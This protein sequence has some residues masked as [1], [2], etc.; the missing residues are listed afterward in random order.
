M[1]GIFYISWGYSRARVVLRCQYLNT[2]ITRPRYSGEHNK[3]Q[4]TDHN[5]DNRQTFAANGCMCVFLPIYSGR[6]I[7]WKYQPGSH[8]ISHPPSSAVR[9]F[10]FFARRIQPLPSLLDRGVELRKNPS[11]RDSNS[12]P[13]VSERLRDYQLSYCTGT[14][15]GKKRE[16]KEKNNNRRKEKRNKKNT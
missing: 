14:K 12:R 8:R 2:K 11:Y 16:K 15:K 3:R 7:R 1:Y 10:I 13:N 4:C 6:Q 9:A 5:R